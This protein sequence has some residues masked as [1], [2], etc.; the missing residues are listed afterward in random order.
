VS[1]KSD[2][3][4]HPLRKLTKYFAKK[5]QYLTLFNYS[6]ANLAKYWTFFVENLPKTVRKPSA[7]IKR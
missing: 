6:I 7:L 3:K 5:I 4:L 2:A 1:R